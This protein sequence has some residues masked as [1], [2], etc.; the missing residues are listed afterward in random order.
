ML[1]VSTLY[2]VTACAEILH[3]KLG[4][5]VT[6]TILSLNRCFY[7][8]YA[9]YSL[10]NRRAALS[11]IS[12]SCDEVATSILAV[13]AITLLY[14]K[15]VYKNIGYEKYVPMVY[16]ALFQLASIVFK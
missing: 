9:S 5:G 12:D 11:L 13:Y 7:C 10:P 16:C 4:V 14:D 3:G 2:V 8:L 15:S 1:T 6:H